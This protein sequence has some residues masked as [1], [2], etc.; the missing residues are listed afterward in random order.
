MERVYKTMRSVGIFNIVI[1]IVTII[2]G[3]LI[4]A[5]MIVGGGRLLNRKNDIMF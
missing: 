3:A 1:G 5:F 4:G 2:A